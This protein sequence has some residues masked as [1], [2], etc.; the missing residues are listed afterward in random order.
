MEPALPDT[1]IVRRL[2]ECLTER[3][4]NGLFQ[5]FGAQTV[6][7]EQPKGRQRN[8]TIIVKFSSHEDASYALTRLHQLLV[9]GKR[10]V[11]EYADFTVLPDIPQ[12]NPLPKQLKEE[13]YAK[14][15]PADEHVVNNIVAE[16]LRNADFYQ[17]VLQLMKSMNL[18]P[19]FLH[20]PNQ[21]IIIVEPSDI[22]EVE[23]E[24]LYKE[25]TEESE[26]ETDFTVIGDKEVIP[27][28]S[29]RRKKQKQL[30]RTNKLKLF[31]NPTTV[32]TKVKQVSSAGRTVSEIFEQNE[33]T[34]NKKLEFKISSEVLQV[35]DQPCDRKKDNTGSFGT[36][37]PP[38]ASPKENGQ[39]IRLSENQSD[40]DN[41][42]FISKRKLQINKLQEEE[43][44]L[45]PIFKNYSAGVPGSRL[46]VKNLAKTIKESDLKHIF[47][48][49]VLWTSEEERNMFDIRLMTEGRMKGQ[50]F[51]TLP[52][53]DRA[54]EALNETNGVM[55]QGKPLVVHFARS[56][57][58]NIPNCTN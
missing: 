1:L 57:Q 58:T 5:F 36:F 41:Y 27:N 19:P 11:A 30:K 10:I 52:N 15:P 44:K 45:L 2:P 6:K 26:L 8:S 37:D 7:K 55:L 12:T 9:L 40:E 38:P 47:G 31:T 49:Y 23:M 53:V 32:P 48:R 17:K 13:N 29:V 4:L 24:E 56:A 25:E 51:I 20:T 18:A 50:A 3:D 39:Q 54:R 34:L 14:Y 42:E 22:E 46:Y 28:I 21:P 35:N 16:L 43:M 33:L